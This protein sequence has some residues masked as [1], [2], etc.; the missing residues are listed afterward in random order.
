MAEVAVLIVTSVLSFILGVIYTTFRF[1]DILN[2]WELTTKA[3]LA[4][5]SYLVEKE[6]E[7]R[8]Q[9]NIP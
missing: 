3:A 9:C 5:S 6:L 1:R 8:K 4:Q 7:R 2:R